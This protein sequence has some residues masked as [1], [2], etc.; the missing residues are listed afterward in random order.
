MRRAAT[1]AALTPLAGLRD[2]LLTLAAPVEARPLPAF[3]AVGATLAEAMVV[4]RPVPASAVALIAG[5]AVAAV[6]TVGA[7]PYAPALPGRLVAVAA[8]DPLPAGCDAVVPADAV[9]RDFGPEA[10]QQAVAPGENVRRAGDDIAVGT[11]LAE[12]GT[13]VT[14]HLALVATA[15]GHGAVAVSRPRLALGH[16]GSAEA[17]IAARFLAARFADGSAE[18]TLAG[19][20]AAAGLG[21]DL[22]L[23]IGGAEIGAADA[24]LAVLDRTGRRLGHGAAITGLESLAWGEIGGRPALVMPRRPEAVMVACL[25]LIEPLLA[26]LDGAAPPPP[27]TR[28][29]A[30]K[31][32]SRV[33]LAE[34]AL[35]GTDDAGRW[36]PLGVGDLAW[37]ALARAEAFVELPPE[38]EGLAEAS[39][40][41]ARRLPAF[42]LRSPT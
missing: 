2:H 22:T 17:E 25:A 33:G 39:P 6:D 23:L 20:D 12:A 32:V 28:P 26:A 27:E 34:I 41:A 9:V 4:D 13:P 15:I 11:R 19:L 1:T 5:R 40:L 10:V 29:I 3:A 35:L 24:A 38:S 18:V 21:A 36:L 42:S 7:S 31:I 14:P 16:D 37:A 8:G 30:R